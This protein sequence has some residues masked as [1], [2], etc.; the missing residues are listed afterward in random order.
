MEDTFLKQF[1]RLASFNFVINNNNTITELFN[2]IINLKNV[3]CLE[4]LNLSYQVILETELEKCANLKK[5]HI[6]LAHV[7]YNVILPIN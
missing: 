6:I 1:L 7:P 5:L 4:L 2:T 3:E